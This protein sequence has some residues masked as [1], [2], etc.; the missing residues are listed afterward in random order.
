M[1]GTPENLAAMNLK[2]KS[3]NDESI[4]Y[5]GW[6]RKQEIHVLA[7]ANNYQTNKPMDDGEWWGF[8]APTTANSSQA[9]MC[10]L[11]IVVAKLTARIP[12]GG[13][14]NAPRDVPENAFVIREEMGIWNKNQMMSDNAV[15]GS[16]KHLKVAAPMSSYPVPNYVGFIPIPAAN[17]DGYVGQY[18]AHHATA[19]PG[20]GRDHMSVAISVFTCGLHLFNFQHI[21]EHYLQVHGLPEGVASLKTLQTITLDKDTAFTCPDLRNIED[22]GTEEKGLAVDAVY[23]MSTAKGI[24]KSSNNNRSTA[25]LCRTRSQEFL[26]EVKKV[27][28]VKFYGRFYMKL[29]RILKASGQNISGDFSVKWQVVEDCLYGAVS[30]VEG[31]TRLDNYLNLNYTKFTGATLELLVYEV[32]RE[33]DAY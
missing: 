15:E 8:R 4:G 11:P 5:A 2:I 31:V 1:G 3:I 13:N 6:T 27:C 14:Y 21:H 25:D 16:Y 30:D 10:N 32:D 9:P 17:T 18:I 7:K 22:V 28:Q 12:A 20:L 33:V 19:Y 24:F 23:N 26:R 29:G